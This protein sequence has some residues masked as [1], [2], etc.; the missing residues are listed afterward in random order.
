MSFDLSSI[1]RNTANA[2]PRIFIY[3]VEGIGK[4]TF[5][6][7]APKPIF[8]PTED[9]LGRLD[10]EHFPI[11]RST[12]DIEAAIGTLY[13]NDTGFKTVVLDSADWTEQFIHKE[14]K[15]QHDSKE[16]AYGKEAVLAAEKWRR[17][18]D[19][20]DALRADKGFTVIIIAHCQIKR[21]DSP[22]VEPYDRYQPKLQDRSNSIL[23]EWADAVLFANWQTLTKKEDAG[24]FN[25]ERFRGVSTGRR[26]LH[27]AER[28][29]HMAKN[30]YSLPDTIDLDWNAFAE[31][32][33]P[34]LKIQAA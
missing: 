6:A 1:K 12:D 27:T 31:L 21:F 24:G 34:A 18:I 26:L 14:L 7:M 20:F 5:G 4:S 10:V 32:V 28:P 17:I 33:N 23:R 29:S 19:G 16:L 22:E 25:K 13:N 3:G 11:A 30:R 2:A 9:G 15:D 8:I